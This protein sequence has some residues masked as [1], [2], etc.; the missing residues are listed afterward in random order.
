VITTGSYIDLVILRDRDAD[1]AWTSASDGTLEERIYY[2]QNWRADVV[3][4]VG[5][6]GQSGQ[7]KEWV[8]YSAYGVPYGIPGGDTDSDFD[9]E[10]GDV[11]QVQQWIDTSAYDLR[12]DFNLDGAVDAS[13]KSA[14]ILSQENLYLGRG[15]LSSVSSMKG[16]SGSSRSSSTALN[17]ARVR[18]WNPEEGRWSKRDPVEYGDS[19]N[20]YSVAQDNPVTLRDPLGLFSM[21]PF[22]GCNGCKVR[23]PKCTNIQV[24]GGGCKLVLICT[25]GDPGARVDGHCSSS[26]SGHTPFH[27]PI[28]TANDCFMVTQCRVTF[29]LTFKSKCSA[30]LNLGKPGAWGPSVVIPPHPT[31][32]SVP[33]RVAADCGGSA[34]IQIKASTGDSTAIVE[35]GVR[36]TH[37]AQ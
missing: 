18:M 25:P 8:K 15:V 2:C 13:D 22:T 12:G 17:L 3:A 4:I 35:V 26:G 37:C 31:G 32:R 16:Y 34:S 24:G 20:L 1:T 14:I 36:C 30:R 5:P 27:A 10:T 6:D 21:T 19:T 11:D 7:M 23:S 29:Q 33:V 28:D 9:C